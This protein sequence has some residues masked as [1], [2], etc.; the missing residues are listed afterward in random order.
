MKFTLTEDWKAILTKA[1]SIKFSLLAALCG[2][3]EFAV[4]QLAPAGV[5]DGLF[6][7]AA[8]VLSTLTPA[9]RIMAQKELTHAKDPNSP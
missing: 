9:V 7:I 1:W 8:I 4:D 5:P 3:A 6:A 2:V